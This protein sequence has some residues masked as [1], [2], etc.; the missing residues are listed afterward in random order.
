MGSKNC[1]NQPCFHV[2]TLQLTMM[3]HDVLHGWSRVFCG[4]FRQLHGNDQK[5]G[6]YTSSSCQ[7]K[8]GLPYSNCLCMCN[9]SSRLWGEW[10][11]NG[12]TRFETLELTTFLGPD[13]WR[14]AARSSSCSGS[15][16]PI[17]G[18]YW[19]N[20]NNF[21]HTIFQGFLLIT[22]QAHALVCTMT[23]VRSFLTL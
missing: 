17:G 18:G 7:R 23:T 20:G 9:W 15:K 2:W 16:A 21:T 6:S 10:C 11:C 8:Q 3:L 19:L 14:S 4:V 22:F 5:S 13:T 12:S 1:C